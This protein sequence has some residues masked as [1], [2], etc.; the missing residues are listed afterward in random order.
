MCFFRRRYP[1]APLFLI[2]N[3]LT[4]SAAARLEAIGRQLGDPG[5]HAPAQELV[6]AGHL[7]GDG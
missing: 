5:A 2:V 3:A 6:V 7:P 1:V 4:L